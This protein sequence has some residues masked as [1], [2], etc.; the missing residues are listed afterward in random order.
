VHGDQ[1]FNHVALALPDFGH[2]DCDGARH[3]AEPGGVMR[4]MRDFRTPDFVLAGEAVD[5]GAGAADPPAL[6]HGRTSSGPR[7]VPG[8]VLATLPTAKDKGFVPFWLSHRHLQM[9]GPRVMGGI[10]GFGRR[11]GAKWRPGT[12]LQVPIIAGQAHA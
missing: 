1:A 10:A 3:R 11:S 12:T 2:I 8:Q 7:H 5:V 6:H 4:Q 9:Q